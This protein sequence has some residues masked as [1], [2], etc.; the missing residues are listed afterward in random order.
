MKTKNKKNPCFYF[1]SFPVWPL[2]ACCLFL[3]EKFTCQNISS[4]FSPRDMKL[5]AS[6][7]KFLTQTPGIT[8]CWQRWHRLLIWTEV[9][10]RLYYRHPNTTKLRLGY[11]LTGV[12]DSVRGGGGEGV[13]VPT[14]TTGHMTGGRGVSV[15]GRGSL[16]GRA[17]VQ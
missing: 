11:V 14:C 2:T 7:L 13:S 10:I 9:I 1:K 12:C 17:L 3:S 6:K 16:L 5:L 8:I 15:Q 4:D